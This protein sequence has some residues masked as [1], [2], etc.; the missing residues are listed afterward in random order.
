[1][2]ESEIA[3]RPGVGGGGISFPPTPDG[4]AADPS[5]ETSSVAS[6][7]KRLATLLCW[8]FSF[9]AL[10][11]TFLVGRVFV[12]ARAF[13]VDPDVWWHIRVGQNILATHHWPTND[14]FSFTVSGTPWLA[15]EW[16]GDVLIGSVE[17]FAG[18]RGLDA[19]LIV[20]ASAVMLALYY[21]ATLR[22]GN[23]KAGFSAAVLLCSL[24]F[25][26]FNLRPQMLGYLFLILTLIVLEHFRRGKSR[27]L[28]FLPPLFLI[29]INT[30]GSWVSGLGVIF[31]FWA[32]GL[33]GFHL[34]NVKARRWSPTERL[35]LEFAFLL[36]I[37]T[38]AFTPYGTR[39]AAYPFTV[40]TSLPVNVGNVFEWFPMPFNVPE[41]KLFLAVV[42]GF[43]VAQMVVR[44]VWQLAEL[45][46]FFFGTMMAC[47]HVRFLVF[48]VPFF[49]PLFATLVAQWFPRYDR[50][51]EKYV[52]NAILMTAAVAAIVW[53]FPSR[54][55][56]QKTVEQGFPVKAVEYLRQHPVPGPM[57]NTYRFGGY[58]VFSR[59]PEQKVFIDGRGDLYE[60]NGVFS[61]YLAIANLKPPAF[62]VLKVY[63]IQTCVL[64][65]K[66]PL[67]T[68]LTHHPDWKQVYADD[69]SVLFVRKT[70]LA[71]GSNVSSGDRTLLPTKLERT[72]SFSLR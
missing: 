37:A 20:M 69:V 45:A 53:Y 31:V 49:A 38:I 1:M 17:R 29:W 36:C 3:I 47:L 4:F 18:L 21:Y 2:S 11:G 41:G 56:L 5:V 12:Q 32:C 35:R 16:L 22:S 72:S 65:R 13:F 14:P 54:A 71:T 19:L 10:L 70:F 60:V 33:V 7:T 55:D 34:G 46:L 61:D 59:W 6:N 51:K 8:I 9:P 50:T 52:P 40:A 24:A 42:L 25:A 62:S 44:P 68:V 43:F 26:S 27:A 28:W 58:L 15:Y 39:L 57:Y 64:E 30:H 63:G 67:A 23:S 66:E 48:F